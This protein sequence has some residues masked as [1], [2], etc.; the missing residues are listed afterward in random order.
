MSV[1]RFNKLIY[2]THEYIDICIIQVTHINCQV[3]WSI[4]FQFADVSKKYEGWA[5]H[6][7]HFLHTYVPTN[8]FPLS[9]T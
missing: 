2:A 3:F 6:D 1:K 8:I 5:C 7:I 9:I 4:V